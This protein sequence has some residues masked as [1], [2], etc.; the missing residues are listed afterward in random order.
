MNVFC[1]FKRYKICAHKL[2]EV[3]LKT[4][5]EK[6]K[7]QFNPLYSLNLEQSTEKNEEGDG[8][9]SAESQKSI[10]KVNL[11]LMVSIEKWCSSHSSTCQRI[12]NSRAEQKHILKLKKLVLILDL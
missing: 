10:E 3:I 1:Y 2:S 6:T 7:V 5:S 9:E 8:G 4:S 11:N 12:G